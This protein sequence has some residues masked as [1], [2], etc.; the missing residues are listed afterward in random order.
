MGIFF[1]I[2]LISQFIKIRFKDMQLYNKNKI[3]G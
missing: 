3:D 1:L 2:I